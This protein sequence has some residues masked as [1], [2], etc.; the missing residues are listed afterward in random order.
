MQLFLWINVRWRKLSMCFDWSEVTFVCCTFGR[1]HAVCRIVVRR[2]L[3]VSHVCRILLWI[4]MWKKYNVK[5]HWYLIR[6]PQ[7]R[8]QGWSISPCHF[9]SQHACRNGALPMVARL[10]TSQHS[11]LVTGSIHEPWSVTS[12]VQTRFAS[13]YRFKQCHNMG[14]FGGGWLH[15]TLELMDCFMIKLIRWNRLFSVMCACSVQTNVWN[16]QQFTW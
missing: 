7:P 10:R 14:K 16:G 8:S 12:D 15:Q 13:S 1:P 4:S 5:V 2:T 6:A 9:F 11:M 3:Y